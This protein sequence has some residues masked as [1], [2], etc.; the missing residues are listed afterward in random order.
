MVRKRLF[1][2]FISAI[3]FSLIS[4]TSPAFAIFGGTP[5]IGNKVVVALIRG[6]FATTSGC[7]GGLVA[8]RIVLTA[9]HCLTGT[10][11]NIWIAEPGS[12]LRDIKTK[13]IQVAEFFIPEGFSTEKFP[14]QNDF[15]IL[16]LKSGFA[17]HETLE[18]A[19]LEQIQKWINDEASVTHVGY[20]CTA[21]VDS[22]PCGATSPIPN[23]FET[24]FN[25]L[26]PPQF[27]SLIPNT[28]SMTK[29]SIDKTICGG[30]SGSPL[31]KLVD[32]KWIYIGAQSSSNG[33]GCTKSCNEICA[34]TQGLP[35][36]NQ[37][38]VQAALKLVAAST[39]TPTPS[40][41]P[42]PTPSSTPSVP[43]T[44]KSTAKMKTITCTKGKIIKKVTALNP[45]C[46][47]GYRKK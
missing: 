37:G 26:T 12:D 44:P 23:Q 21:L 8:P 30:D 6:E 14:Y 20:G 39:P 2:A 4:I 7:S 19:S 24:T 33:A 43:V 34:A 36:V 35:A 10:A 5:A 3:L 27:T 40:L 11:S 17:G 29:I 41:A 32:G 9:A 22:P 28:F 46:P 25:K 31:L 16:V 38:M 47:T 15:G 45:K 42:T 13:R 18:L 1:W